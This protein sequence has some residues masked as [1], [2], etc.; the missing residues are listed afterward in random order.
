MVGIRI[1][2]GDL[3]WLSVRA[4]RILDESGF[5]RARIVASNEL[6]EYLI[7]SLKEQGA[8]IDV[9]GV[10]T[11]LVTAHDSPALGGVYKLSAIRPTGGAWEP[12]IKLSEQTAKITVPGV[13]GVKRYFDGARFI[14]DMVYDVAEEP[15]ADVLMIDP[16]DPT[17]RKRFRGH[18]F[19][20][21]LEP[22]M[23]RGSRVGEAASLEEAR[24][25]AKAE[26]GSLDAT[27]TRFLN[28]HSYPVGLERTLHERRW[29]L[30]LAARK[31]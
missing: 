4:R 13:L 10:G 11:K 28:P 8:A 12:R 21:L 27:R 5:P 30:I 29:E 23:R 22:V 18:N 1:D 19:R 20:D 7:S 9:W 31:D 17:R 14:G 25:R 6:D 3:A 15:G 26:V 24:D 16:A 2:S